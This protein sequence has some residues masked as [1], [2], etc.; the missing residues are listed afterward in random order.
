M[1]MYGW[2]DE[3]NRPRFRS[4]VQRICNY[5]TRSSSPQ[6]WIQRQNVYGSSPTL[7]GGRSRSPSWRRV[8]GSSP[9]KS[10]VRSRSPSWRRGRDYLRL[11]SHSRSPQDHRPHC[12]SGSRYGQQFTTQDDNQKWCLSPRERPNAE[13]AE[14]LLMDQAE[15]LMSDSSVSWCGK[16]VHVT[17]A[18][19]GGASQ[20]SRLRGQ[21]KDHPSYRR[22]LDV[23]SG[24]RG[25]NLLHDVV[26][27]RVSGSRE[28][29]WTGSIGQ[30]SS[31]SEHSA[32]GILGSIAMASGVSSLLPA[33]L[34]QAQMGNVSGQLLNTIADPMLSHK[35][36]AGLTQQYKHIVANRQGTVRASTAHPLSAI[37]NFCAAP[38]TKEV[39]SNLPA[40]VLPRPDK[41]TLSREFP[42]SSGS[43][44]RT[45]EQMLRGPGSSKDQLLSTD[46][47]QPLNLVKLMAERAKASQLLATCPGD[48]QALLVLAKTQQQ[49]QNASRTRGAIVPGQ[50]MGST[51][52]QVL[53]KQQLAN[54]GRQAW[55]NKDQFVRAPPVCG[56]V[57]AKL[58]RKMGWR[59]GQCLGR[60]REGLINPITVDFKLDRCGLST[61]GEKIHKVAVSGGEWAPSHDVSGK[62]PVCVLTEIC[63]K[64][65]WPNARFMLAQEAGPN[66][67][68]TFIYRVVVNGMPYQPILPSPNKKTAKAAAAYAALQGLGA[69]HRLP[70]QASYGRVPKEHPTPS[71]RAF[72]FPL[73]SRPF[74]PFTP[75]VPSRAL[76]PLQQMRT[77]PRMHM[78]LPRP[79]WP[80]L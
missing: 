25:K 6:T 69:V 53:S 21:N 35:L 59:E 15:V 73:A 30:P 58:M 27:A 52:A 63:G 34:K 33:I 47:E 44:H 4:P 62:H 17:G 36:L 2:P 8:S 57:G 76:V 48:P 31:P 56:G 74:L 1:N 39:S 70:S 20:L 65:H 79:S 40:V 68:K 46:M 12:E 7:S 28:K 67:K 38:G 32:M 45:K 22:R 72:P 50:F 10:R 54:P 9:T 13:C 41:S 77:R 19:Q 78:F 37:G 60:N 66:H 75:V 18:Q 23:T 11:R 61:H 5:R 24:P 3:R 71:P 42:V 55:S 80:P 26:H 16:G 43:Q 51:G 49:V 14:H 64:R 29:L